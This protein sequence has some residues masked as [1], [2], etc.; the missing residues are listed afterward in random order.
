[1]IMFWNQDNMR[2]IQALQANITKIEG[3]T[4]KIKIL[5]NNWPAFL[6]KISIETIWP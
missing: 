6:D 3:I 2:A 1:M 4:K 5:T